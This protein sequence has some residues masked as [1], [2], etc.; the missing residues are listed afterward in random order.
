MALDPEAFSAAFRKS[1]M[2]R[3]KLV[4]LR[5]NAPVV[6]TNEA[7][8][9]RT[10]RVT[11]DRAPTL[12]MEAREC[13]ADVELLKYGTEGAPWKHDLRSNRER[14][15]ATWLRRQLG[16]EHVGGE[17]PWRTRQQ[18]VSRRHQC[19]RDRPLEM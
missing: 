17:Q 10:S 8:R 15:V 6:L 4:G 16:G 14:G 7:E 18:F 19:G 11:P 9:R 12:R 3:A 13:D 2:K 1:P 5:R